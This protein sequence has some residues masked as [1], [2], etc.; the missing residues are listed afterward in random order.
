MSTI[1]QELLDLHQRYFGSKPVVV[2]PTPTYPSN[3]AS[4]P[5]TNNNPSYPVRSPKGA[6]LAEEFLNVEIWLP[7]TLKAL[8]TDMIHAKNGTAGE[9][10]LP[11]ATIMISGDASMIKT[12]LNQ[13]K[14]TAKELYS[15]D[16]Y[17]ISIR[18]FLIDKQTR[19]FPEAEVT[20]LKRLFELGTHFKIDNAATNIFLEDTSLPPDQQYRVVIEKFELT[21]VTGGKKSMRPFRMEISSDYIFTLTRQ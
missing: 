8:P 17:K 2:T 7:I 13:R 14:G 10:Y 9:W 20:Y 11:Y 12:P 19:S 21:D 3:D 6:I 15:I 4:V 5:L 18:G 16:D 1:P